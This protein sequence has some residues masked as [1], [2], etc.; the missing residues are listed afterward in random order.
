MTSLALSA[1]IIGVNSHLVRIESNSVAGNPGAVQ[2]AIAI[3]GLSKRAADLARER[4]RAAIVNS[5]FGLPHGSLQVNLAPADAPNGGV[6]DLAIALG[7]LAADGQVDAATLREFLV[8]GELGLDGGLRAIQGVIPMLRTARRSGIRRVIVPAQHADEAALIDGIEVNGVSTLA[9][10]VAV[11]FDTGAAFVNRGSNAI[12]D[13]PAEVGDFAD[14][15][16][17]ALAKRALEIA[18]AGGHHVTLCGPPGSGKTMLA[19]RLPS[20]LPPMSD[21]EALDVASVYS[22]AGLLTTR[23]RISRNRPFRAPHWTATRMSLTGGGSQGKHPGEFSLAHHGVLYLDEATEYPRSTW[24]LVRDAIRDG[25]TTVHRAGQSVA[26]DARFMLAVSISS[27]ACGFAGVR[28]GSCR[29]DDAALARYRKAIDP[30]MQ[31]T[32]MI[33]PV[34]RVSYDELVQARASESSAAIRLRVM[35]AREVQ[36]QRA[37]LLGLPAGTLNEHLPAHVVAGVLMESEAVSLLEAVTERDGGGAAR[38]RIVRIAL[39]IADLGGSRKIG[40]AHIAEALVY[41]PTSAATVAA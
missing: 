6:H 24:P 26:F 11:L 13:A 4:I 17:Q 16:G 29:C 12:Q 39:T 3:T 2:P 19:R 28:G 40:R 35:A 41:R 10:A 30:L 7:L 5:G 9:E 8:L 25:A 20:I 33:S 32:S 38:E 21:E 14:V 27:C 37:E 18:A 34:Q 1:A 22:V 23:A 31:C 15:R 36:A